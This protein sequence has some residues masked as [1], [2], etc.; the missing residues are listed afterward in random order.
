MQV[1]TNQ[2]DKSDDSFITLACVL[3]VEAVKNCSLSPD[4]GPCKALMPSWFFNSTAGVCAVFMYGGC[5]GNNNRFTSYDDCQ[6]SCHGEFEVSTEQT[7][8]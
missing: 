7:E 2:R 1:N 3:L 6:A 8:Q 5:D 4:P